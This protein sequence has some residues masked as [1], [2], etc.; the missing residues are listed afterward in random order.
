MNKN[1]VPIT[2]Y[3]HTK[4][5]K[6]DFFFFFCI[7]NIAKIKEDK[8]LENKGRLCNFYANTI[9]EGENNKGAIIYPF[10]QLNKLIMRIKFCLQILEKQIGEE[11]PILKRG[12]KVAYLGGKVK[13]RAK[14]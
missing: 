11:R 8:R 13:P 5:K 14:K 1:D 3:Y 2:N 7:L 6:S 12:E 9:F 10:L 4:L